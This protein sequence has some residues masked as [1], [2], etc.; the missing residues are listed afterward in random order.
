MPDI[1]GTFLYAMYSVIHSPYWTQLWKWESEISQLEQKTH[2]PQIS[3]RTGAVP[4]LVLN[5][6][7]DFLH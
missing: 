1:S 3:S 5:N 2:N 7:I 4:F 6:S